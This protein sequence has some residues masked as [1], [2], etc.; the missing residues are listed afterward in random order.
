[1]CIMHRKGIISG[2]LCLLLVLGSS[3]RAGEPQTQPVGHGVA[4]DVPLDLSGTGGQTREWLAAFDV[5]A[6]IFDYTIELRD[7]EEERTFYRVV[8][9]SAFKSPWSQNNIVPCELYVPAHATGRIPAAIVLDILDGSAVLARGLARGL[10]DHGVAALY[11]PMACYNQRRPPGN[12]QAEYVATDPAR[13]VESWRQTVMDIRRAKAVLASRLDIDPQHLG[14]TGI[15]LGGIVTSLAAGVDGTFDRV[16]PILAG[17]NLAHLTFT[18]REVRH[19]RQTLQDVGVDEQRLHKIMAPVEPLNFAS[20]IDPKRCLM[21][22]ALQDEVIPRTATDALIHAIGKPQV[23]WTQAGHYSAV[24]FLPSIRAT[25]AR[26]ICGKSVSELAINE[27]H[28]A[29]TP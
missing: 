16:V 29:K 12:A 7:H 1:M 23:L 11:M 13:A 2:T 20:R 6:G 14:I 25:A 3:L 8:F 4:Q 10:A 18:V 26:F 17:G 22:N 28:G 21:I 27:H 24:L 9:P 5:P 15:S 19:M